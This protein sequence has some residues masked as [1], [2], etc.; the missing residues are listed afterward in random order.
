YWA[1]FKIFR[2]EEVVREGEVPLSILSEGAIQVIQVE[3]SV[4]ESSS[5]FQNLLLK[6]SLLY[7]YIG[8]GVILLILV[9][10]LIW[11]E[12]KRR[13]VVSKVPQKRAKSSRKKSK[14]NREE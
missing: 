8:A 7:F 11:L 9:G 3:E 5:W 1:Q 2:N 10:L 12:R 6:F 13:R 14:K 4:E